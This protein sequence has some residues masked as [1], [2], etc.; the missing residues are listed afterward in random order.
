MRVPDTQAAPLG[1][2]PLILIHATLHLAPLFLN[3][4]NSRDIASPSIGEH[5]M[6]LRDLLPLTNNPMA[7]YAYPVGQ[8]SYMH[9]PHLPDFKQLR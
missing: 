4:F 8:P 9:F 1:C 2:N 7:T 3:F 6:L 5:I